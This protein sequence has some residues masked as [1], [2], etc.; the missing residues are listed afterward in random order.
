[1]CGCLRS[2]YVQIDISSQGSILK[3]I[4][5]LNCKQ[6]QITDIIIVQNHGVKKEHVFLTYC[7]VLSTYPSNSRRPNCVFCIQNMPIIPF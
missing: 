5:L 4:R 3:I 6:H 7:N 2:S 1:M